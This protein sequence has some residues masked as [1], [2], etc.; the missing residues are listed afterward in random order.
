MEKKIDRTTTDSDYIKGA[1]AQFNEWQEDLER[2]ED[3][4]QDAGEKFEQ[5]YNDP[6]A[7]LKAYLNDV[8]EQLNKLKATDSD[9][10]EEQ[11][12]NVQKTGR[13]YHQAYSETM[14]MLKE[15]ERKPAGWLEGF[16]D[17]PPAGSAG[18]LEGFGERPAGSEGWVE[19]LAERTS[20]TK[21]WEEGYGEEN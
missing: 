6:I 8:E 1:E 9:Q 11:R 4:I 12:L 7:K 19:G 15:A 2:L 21:G 14:I 5:A 18:W 17:H 13:T 16:T 20:E 3:M 10:W